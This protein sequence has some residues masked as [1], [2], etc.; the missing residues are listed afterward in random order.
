MLRLIYIRLLWWHPARFRSR[1]GDE[2]LADFDNA[3]N[4]KDQRSLIVD[5][6]RSLIRQWIWRPHH[7]P[8]QTATTSEHILF[9]TIED[10]K[11]APRTILNASVLS[12]VLLCAAIFAI[13]RG[14][15]NRPLFTMGAIHP[16]PGLLSFDRASLA[17]SELNAQIHFPAERQ[18]PWR[19]IAILYFKNILVLSALDRDTDYNISSRELAAAHS[20]LQALDKDRDGT[21]SPEEC[22]H[23]LGPDAGAQLAPDIVL[24][25]RL[26]FIHANPA[27][28]AL[29][30][31]NNG[32]LSMSEIRAAR[33][34]LLT[35]DRNADR[36]LSPNEVIPDLVTSQV[37]MILARLDKDGDDKLTMGERLNSEADPL[38]KI[39]ETADRNR[40]NITTRQ[41]LTDRLQLSQEIKN[42]LDQAV[43]SL[44]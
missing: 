25:A 43:R 13:G 36:T 19:A 10:H 17:E 33:P 1:F 21:L 38:R 12:T 42:R 28:A 35:L 31:D 30:I 32:S 24:R 27:L 29:D 2:M 6:M 18:D 40:D 20:A 5:G 16:R 44:P 41:E 9:Q 8:A 3:T 14:G 39:I 22:G 7:A 11:L 23:D 37:S 4:A 26:H 15:A 34:S